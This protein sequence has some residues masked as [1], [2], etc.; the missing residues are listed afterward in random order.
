MIG[1]V[2]KPNNV[3]KDL[4]KHEE[5]ILWINHFGTDKLLTKHMYLDLL[6]SDK[7]TKVEE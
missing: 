6:R 1:E 5:L 2:S 7:Y 4:V 3:R